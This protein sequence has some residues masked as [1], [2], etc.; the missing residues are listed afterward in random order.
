MRDRIKAALPFVAVAALLVTGTSFIVIE[1]GRAPMLIDSGETRQ[2]V[3]RE[4]NRVAGLHPSSVDEHAFRAAWE[5]LRRAEYVATAWLIA[6]DG[7]IVSAEGSTAASAG[8]GY[9]KDL[10]LADARRLVESAG[11][12]LAA[13]QQQLLLA[14]SAIQREGEHN[15]IYRHMVRAVRDA[16]GRQVGILGVAYD[17]SPALG[18]RVSGGYVATIIVFT[19]ALIIFWLALPVWVF[20][21]AGERGER[22]SLWASFVLIGNVVALCAYLLTR[23][24]AP[25]ATSLRPGL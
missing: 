21:D 20:M 4:V 11:A 24:A 5:G 15:D 13:D 22:E 14:A 6:A 1:V 16:E 10:A 17:V 9:V 8:A 7:R 23:R 18:A 19:L 12:D 3:Q 25:R 2:V